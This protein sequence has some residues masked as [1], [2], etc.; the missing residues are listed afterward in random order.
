MTSQTVALAECM[1]GKRINAGQE[2]VLTDIPDGLIKMGK[3]FIM[4][5]KETVSQNVESF[6]VK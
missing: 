5:Q 3:D 1:T 4:N 2:K 6:I